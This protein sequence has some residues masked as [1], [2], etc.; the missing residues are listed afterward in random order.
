MN[1]FI[2][3]PGKH[4]GFGRGL[5][6]GDV[7][8]RY[9]STEL[10]ISNPFH[11]R[12]SC[13]GEAVIRL[14][15]SI[16]RYGIIE[17]LAVRRFTCGKFEIVFGERRLQAARLIDL[18]SVPCIILENISRRA[19]CELAYAENTMR[20]PLNLDEKAGGVEMLIRKFGMS[21]PQVCESLS[22]YRNEMNFLMEILRLSAYER[23]L[24]C[25]S[26]LTAAH[27]RPLMKIENTNVRRHLMTV[28]AEKQ[29]SPSGCERFIE[30]F[31]RTP[32]EKEFYKKKPRPHPVKR[33]V[34]KDLRVFM[35]SIDR[36]VE[37]VRSS[38]IDV[39]CDKKESEDGVSYAITLNRVASGGGKI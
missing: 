30:E 26:S 2:F 28:I 21:R 3:F 4:E 9:I 34:L 14:A 32:T 10:I 11:T 38:G 12:K 7:N 25:N 20:E 37:I 19:S 22:I 1:K 5:F 27:L 13:D 24:V 17:P 23:E 18:Q 16:R 6:G 31:L 36:A 29:L 8:I 39:K 15:D 33:L 35:N